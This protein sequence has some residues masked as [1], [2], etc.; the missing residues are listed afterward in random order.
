MGYLRTSLARARGRRFEPAC[1]SNASRRTAASYEVS[2]GWSTPSFPGSSLVDS[3]YRLSAPV[4]TR[5]SSEVPASTLT[6]PSINRGNQ[7]T[8][9]QRL[10]SPQPLA[11]NSLAIISPPFSASV[12]TKRVTVPGLSSLNASPSKEFLP[13]QTNKVVLDL[14]DHRSTP[15]GVNSLPPDRTE[16]RP[17]PPDKG[18][19]GPSEVSGPRATSQSPSP[20]A[21]SAA[22]SVRRAPEFRVSWLEG[23]RAIP[24]SAREKAE[25]EVISAARAELQRRSEVLPAAQ[26]QVEIRV[27]RLTVKVENPTPQQAPPI[28]RKTVPSR[29]DAGFS[30]YFLRRSIS[31]L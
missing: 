20:A 19:D 21:A 12:K 15:G 5:P 8:D 27:E 22:T 13:P 3:T 14:R 24:H 18:T 6:P 17:E 26:T 23:A 9:V 2:S 29:T 31:G 28:N 30:D 10:P 11:G 7:E 16:P 25:R 4:S 1:S